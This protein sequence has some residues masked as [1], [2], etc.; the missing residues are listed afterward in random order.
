MILWALKESRMASM[1]MLILKCA[2]SFYSTRIGG[3]E[4]KTALPR[5]H[6]HWAVGLSVTTGSPKTAFSLARHVLALS[7]LSLESVP[8]SC[9]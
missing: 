8:T 9:C 7:L 1:V 3:I 5:G 4:R 2:S 6:N